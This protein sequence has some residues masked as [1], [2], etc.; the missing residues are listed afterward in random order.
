MTSHVK[1]RKRKKKF[2]FFFLFFF[3]GLIKKRFYCMY[4]NNVIIMY[5]IE[6]NCFNINFKSKR[7]TRSPMSDAGAISRDFTTTKN[8]LA[9]N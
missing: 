4:H 6:F 7:V 9:Y 3:F 2:F 1:N 8:I 5:K